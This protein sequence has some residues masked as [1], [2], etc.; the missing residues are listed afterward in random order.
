MKTYPGIILTGGK[1]RRMGRDKAFLN[2]EGIPLIR[3]VTDAMKEV[4]DEVFLVGGVEEKFASLEFPWFP[5]LVP[6]QGP[7]GGIYTALTHLKADVVVAACDL[8]YVSPSLICFLSSHHDPASCSIT[9][10]RS[11]TTIQ[12]LLGVYGVRCLYE[13]ALFLNTGRRRVKDFLDE[14]PT[15]FLSLES[16]PVPFPEQ[17]LLNLNT[18]QDI[19]LL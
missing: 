10:V 6:D 11:K 7:L 15:A 16:A 9:V 2:V 3:R 4:C 18:P 19:P 1:S 14:V 5:D 17:S 13:L 8:P 12:P